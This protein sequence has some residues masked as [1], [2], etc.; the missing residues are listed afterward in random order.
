MD[1]NYREE[2]MAA[3]V[4]LCDQIAVAVK[5]VKQLTEQH[6][7]DALEIVKLHREIAGGRREI[8]RLNDRVSVLVAESD[9]LKQD[10]AILRGYVER[11]K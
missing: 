11:N 10:N 6:E 5:T 9:R 8:N 7:K 4:Q 1:E 2:I 3:A